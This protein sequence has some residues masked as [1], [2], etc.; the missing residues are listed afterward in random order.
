MRAEKLLH[1]TLEENGYEEFVTK[2]SGFSRTIVEAMERH[3]KDFYERK[4][5]NKIKKRKQKA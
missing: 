1:L 5:K 2:G 3:A 4:M